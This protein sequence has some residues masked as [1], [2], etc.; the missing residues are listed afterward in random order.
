MPAQWK[1]VAATLARVFL[2]AALGQIIAFGNG[3]LDFTGEQ[4]RMV[5]AAG[6]AAVI[7][8]GMRWLNP[9]DGAYGRGHVTPDVTVADQADGVE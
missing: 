3:V 5:L 2:A 4:W 1:A 8:A 6:I 7:V 9:N